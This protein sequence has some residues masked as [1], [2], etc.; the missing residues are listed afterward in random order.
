[1]VE[2][3]SV[4]K[5]DGT[6]TTFVVTDQIKTVTVTYNGILPIFSA[7][8]RAWSP[9]ASCATTGP[10]RRIPCSRSTTRIYMPRELAESLKEKGVK[11]GKGADQ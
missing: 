3:G 8:G 6:L 10:S 9:K 11:L 2:D 5:G 4:K 7:K 1:M